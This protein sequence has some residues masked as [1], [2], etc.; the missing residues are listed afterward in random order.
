M[1][2]KLSDFIHLKLD[3]EYLYKKKTK[4]LVINQLPR[5]QQTVNLKC[6]QMLPNNKLLCNNEQSNFITNHRQRSS[7]LYIKKYM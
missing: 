1:K 3:R 5:G 2:F 6:V 7:I 4:S